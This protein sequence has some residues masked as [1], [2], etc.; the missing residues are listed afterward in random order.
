MATDDPSGQQPT[1]AR[2][3]VEQRA[4]RQARRRRFFLVSP[5]ILIIGIIMLIPL[6]LMLVYSF[7]EAG[8]YGGVVWDLSAEGYVGFLFHRTLDGSLEFTDSYLRIFG[9]SFTL[10]FVT[11]VIALVLAFPAALFMAMQPTRYRALL[12][13]L[14]TI[15]FWTNLL[16]RNYAWILLLRDIGLINNLLANIGLPTLPLMY[17][18]FAITLGLVYSFVPFMVLPIYSSLEKIDW[19][20]VEAGQDL[21]ANRFH[22]LKR[23]IIPLAKPGIIAGSILVFV[24]SLGAYVTPQLLG[25]GRNLMIGNLIQLQFG[26]SQNWPFGAALAFILLATVLLFLITW[27]LWA[28][29]KGQ[30]HSMQEQTVG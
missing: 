2:S 11:V 9:R 15:P 18:N 4:G 14:V 28:W 26:E 29:R 21:G 30:L 25:G 17:N 1:A 10:S 8:R 12:I 23:I 7:L 16:V 22:S 20:L 27:A 13:F 19:S 3:E 24:P 5:A 6:G